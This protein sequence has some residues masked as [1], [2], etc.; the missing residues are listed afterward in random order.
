MNHSPQLRILRFLPPYSNS[1]TKPNK[2]RNND[3]LSKTSTSASVLK[4]EPGAHP[5]TCGTN[6]ASEKTGDPWA[7]EE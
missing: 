5:R 6:S 2:T 7:L 3:H 1:R 4:E